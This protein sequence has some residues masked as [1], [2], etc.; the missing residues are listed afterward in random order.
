MSLWAAWL[1]V[2]L[3]ISL[4]VYSQIAIKKGVLRVGLGGRVYRFAR[5]YL[6]PWILSGLGAAVLGSFCWIAAMTKLPLS[7]A[8]PF[9]SLG[10]VLV[11]VSGALFFDE[12]ISW[13]R[14]AGLA[15]VVTGL[16]LVAISS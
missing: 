15:L 9:T 10:F 7:L 8:Y 14:L 16:S 4:N 3:T 1:A 6:D 12:P 2:G 13:K 11:S 5:V